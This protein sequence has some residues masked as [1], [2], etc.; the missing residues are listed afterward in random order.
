MCASAETPKQDVIEASIYF[1]T[2]VYQIEKP[3]F[4]EAVGKVSE[5]A[6]VEA[7]K[8]QL[9]E[10][11]P[12]HM[13]G[14]LFDKPEI[15]P[16]QYYVGGTAVNL[17]NEQGYNLEGFEAYFSEMWCQE[18]FK[19]S[20]MEQ[21]VHGAGSQMVGFYFLEAP[22]NCSK[23]VFHDP[24]A[25]KPMISWNE[26]DMGQATFASNAINFTPKAGMLMFTNAWL[27]HSFTRHE[28]NEPIKFIH[29]NLSLRRLPNIS[30]NNSVA[31]AAE[32]V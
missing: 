2:I 15:I 11:Y 22:E 23:V 18:H 26:K 12:V 28:A 27:P 29:F 25:G 17:L 9:N 20:A 24:R 14:N 8:K 31:A 7:R 32:I 16:F 10:I 30:F 3:E 1:P 13:T 4:L 5:E 19:H 21:H 6:L